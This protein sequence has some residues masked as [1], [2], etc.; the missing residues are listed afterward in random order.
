M[1]RLTKHMQEKRELNYAKH[2]RRSLVDLTAAL[3]MLEIK[4]KIFFFYRQK[5]L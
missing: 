5:E 3:N 2:Q 4:K 1:W